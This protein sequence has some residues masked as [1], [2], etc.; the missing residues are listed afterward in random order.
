MSDVVT[1]KGTKK[2]THL[3]KSLFMTGNQCPKALWLSRYRPELKKIAL[4]Q[5]RV[6]SSGT[7]VG[8]LAQQLFPG[9][10]EI[11]FDGTTLEQQV[12]LTRKA[13]ADGARVLYEAAFQFEGVFM[14]GDIL[15]KAGSHWHLYE[16]KS[17][18]G[19]K[20]V[21]LDDIALQYHVLK[22]A[23]VSVTRAH[24]VH[25]DN[26]YVRKGKIDP[27]SL[28]AVVDLTAEVKEAQPRIADTLAALRRV[29][30]GKEPKVDIGSHCGD[31]YECFFKPHCWAHIPENS[32]FTLAGQGRPDPFK[33][34]RQGI[35]KLED[36]PRDSLK[37]KQ[38]LQWDG[39]VHRRNH[40]DR[41]KIQTFLDSLQ[42]PLAFLDF[43]TTGMA[44]PVPLFEKSRPYQQIPFQFSLHVLKRRQGKLHHH[45]FLAG[46]TKTPQR[47]FL[48]A[49]L[50]ALPEK[51]S[52][53]TWNAG[54]E[55]GRLREL[56]QRFP[57]KKAALEAVIARIVDLMGSFLRKE[58][59]HWQFEG[60]YSIKKVLPALVP[61]LSYEGMEI[62]DGGTAAEEWVRMLGLA[63]PAEVEQIRRNLLEYCE[64]DSLAMVRILDR[65]RELAAG[66]G[67]A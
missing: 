61:E 40:L 63:G 39:H 55:V 27:E 12:E 25:I 64:L 24:L 32:V 1:G 58:I 53:L 15:V 4:G 54:F 19:M 49:L 8:I 23:K 10:M 43:E 57:R 62:G 26:T 11:P 18:T 51:G 7:S 16:V 30:L 44:L 17:S 38:Q 67:W 46:K 34:Y 56:A 50:E 14:K 5:Q 59:Y 22:G 66:G 45:E 33:L 35:L 52:I 42:H 28:F 48:D 41:P 20:D 60:S 47:E 31:P 9:G 37:T 21:Y 13:M 36:V 65:V 29:L 3:S 6:L 2:S